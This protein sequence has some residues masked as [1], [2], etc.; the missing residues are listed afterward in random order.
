M[1]DLDFRKEFDDVLV[2]YWLNGLHR[3]D[4]TSKLNAPLPPRL[5]EPLRVAMQRRYREAI[6]EPL[7]VLEVQNIEGQADAE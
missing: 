6:G 4:P 2:G 1:S 3:I 5:W 7:A